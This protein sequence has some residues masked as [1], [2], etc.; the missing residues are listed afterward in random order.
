MDGGGFEIFGTPHLVAIAVTLALPLTLAGAARRAGGRAPMVIA[1]LIAGVLL[2]NEF[3][4]WTVRIS[5]IGLDGWVRNHMPLHVCGVAVLLTAWTLLCR[6]ERTFEIVYFWG[7]VGA[8][9]AV[10]TPGGIGV[11][12]PQ[13]RFFQYFIAHSGIVTGVLFATWGLGMRPTLRGMFRAFG[14]LSIFAAFVAAVNALLGSNFMWLSAAPPGT[15]SPFFALA[16]PWYL[17]VLAAV[18]ITMFFA[19]LSPF[20]AADWWRKRVSGV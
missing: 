9:N 20:L 18:G 16:W 3:T 11:D 4:Y 7:L 1:R 17:P 10:I 12:F 15:V 8:A 6:S 13:Y 5:E 14:V 2:A 19:V